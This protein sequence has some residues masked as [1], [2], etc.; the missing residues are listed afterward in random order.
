MKN[1]KK[2]RLTMNITILGCGRWG[3]FL[4]WYFNDIGHNVL[5]WGRNTS[6]KMKILEDIRRN[7]YVGLSEEIKLSTS[8]AEALAFS[9]DIVIAIKEQN[10]RD[11]MADIVHEN[12]LNK[13]YILCM[14]GL[15]NSTCKRLSEVVYEFV[16]DRAQIAIM[17]G[18]GQPSDLLKGIPTCI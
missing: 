10:L 11:F 8:L 16:E 14:K 13:T 4:A 18:P 5:L 2:G 12:Y 1:C 17:V 6:E 3:T 9:D 7:D 15:E